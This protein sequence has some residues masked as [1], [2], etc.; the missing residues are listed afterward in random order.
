M[1]NGRLP[2]KADIGDIVTVSGYADAYFHVDGFSEY[3]NYEPGVMFS[4]VVY[5]L[6]A[7][8]DY[9][10]GTIAEDSEITLVAKANEAKA[11]IDALLKPPVDYEDKPKGTQI[12]KLFVNLT[13][14]TNEDVANSKPKRKTARQKQADIDGLLDELITLQTVVDICGD[15]ADYAVRIADVKR[16]LGEATA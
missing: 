9:K 11:F 1:T 3:Y 2:R 16:K 15:D 14:I 13:A 7:A 6:S 8:L 10:S 12:D 4:E 5:D